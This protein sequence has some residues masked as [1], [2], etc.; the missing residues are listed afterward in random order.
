MQNFRST[1]KHYKQGLRIFPDEILNDHW[2]YFHGTFSTWSDQIEKRGLGMPEPHISLEQL[3]SLCAIY[4]SMNHRWSNAYGVLESYSLP[5][6]TE[7]GPAVTFL[8]EEDGAAA[9]YARR[10]NAGGETMMTVRDCF[11]DLRKYVLSRTHRYEHIRLQLEMYEYAQRKGQHEPI[12][13]INLGWLKRKIL[14]LKPLEALAKSHINRNVRGVVYAIKFEQA[15]LHQMETAPYDHVL[16]LG[17]IL[18][19]RIV[20]KCTLECPCVQIP[21][22][23]Y[24][25]RSGPSPLPAL[26]EEIQRPRREVQRVDCKGPS[27]RNSVEADSSAGIDI[28]KGRTLTQVREYLS[29]KYPGIFDEV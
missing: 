7:P 9:F 11:K 24:R 17:P 22:G 12:L 26:W 19:E 16:F 4:I 27:G 8:H 15:D 18:R 6:A 21:W 5:R 28:T 10:N 23:R 2:I 29:R 14:E 25:Y 20:A 3:L 13:E 1:A